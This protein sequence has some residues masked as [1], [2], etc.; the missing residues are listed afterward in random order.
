MR[1]FLWTCA[2]VTLN[3]FVFSLFPRCSGLGR[4]RTTRAKTQLKAPKSNLSRWTKRSRSA[5][6]TSETGEG[7]IFLFPNKRRLLF[8]CFKQW[9]GSSMIDGSRLPSWLRN[10]NCSLLCGEQLSLGGGTGRQKNILSASL[11]W[12]SSFNVSLRIFFSLL[13]EDNFLFICLFWSRWS[14]FGFLTLPAVHLEY[15]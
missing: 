8:F 7:F 10:N 4:R 9:Q 2:A 3:F 5:S 12:L 14:L 15:S 1:W 11:K 6:P 13:P